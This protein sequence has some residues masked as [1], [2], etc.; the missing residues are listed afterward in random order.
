[1]FDIVQS[2]ES[3]VYNIA[4]K[5]AR[6]ALAS[7]RRS[8]DDVFEDVRILLNGTMEEEAQFR[9]DLSSIED[10]SCRTT[11]Q[12]QRGM[13][14]ETGISYVDRHIKWL[15]QVAEDDDCL[16]REFDMNDDDF[17]I[18]EFAGVFAKCR[19][20]VVRN[21]Y[22]SKQIQ[23]LRHNITKFITGI[24]D[25]VFPRHM[26]TTI[27]EGG[28]YVERG[29]KRFDIVLPRYVVNS[30]ILVPDAIM[31]FLSHPEI[32][33]DFPRVMSTEALMAEPGCRE[34]MWHTD[35]EYPIGSGY[36]DTFG[37]AGHDL[38]PFALTVVTPLLSGLEHTHG[39]TEFCLGSS[40]LQGL[41]EQTDE[42]LKVYNESLLE[43]GIF[44]DMQ[45]FV[46]TDSGHCPA[47]LWR[48]PLVNPGDAI[49]F[50]F[51]ILH[52]G[53]ANISPDTARTLFVVSYGRAFYRDSNFETQQLTGIPVS[54]PK[55]EMIETCRFADLD[56][57]QSL[58]LDE[59]SDYSDLEGISDWLRN[60]PRVEAPCKEEVTMWVTNVDFPNAELYAGHG[61]IADLPKGESIQLKAECG[62]QLSLRSNN[63]VHRS[64][65]V[66]KS[67]E[68]VVASTEM[69]KS[70]V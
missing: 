31:E 10:G 44:R 23:Y 7:G 8:P 21:M 37:L 20:A 17:D 56:Q 14:T 57:A 49:F 40:Y 26:K 16:T 36:H 12:Q 3:T 47:K 52:R 55:E 62:S 69:T 29:D 39:P 70:S 2:S 58:H 24:D 27:G 25:G 60:Q 22:T 9:E 30:D 32:L 64:W 4:L 45:E 53:G 50:D 15:Q 68:Q 46:N 18:D 19:L 35:D 48:T 33:G 51:S 11:Q 63:I 1:M 6:E 28:F 65:T 67:S 38:P 13:Q 43:A 41:V 34:G 54:D 59:R 5:L 66:H 61:K 42:G